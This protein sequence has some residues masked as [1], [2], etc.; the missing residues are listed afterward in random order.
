MGFD[1][2]VCTNI[3]EIYI[4]GPFAYRLVGVLVY[5]CMQQT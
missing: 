4:K 1:V 3:P 5:M 2:Y